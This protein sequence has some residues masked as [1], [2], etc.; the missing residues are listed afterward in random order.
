MSWTL[1]ATTTVG[2]GGV[3]NIDLQNIPGTYKSLMVLGSLRNEQ[4]FTGLSLT[5]NNNA[6]SYSTRNIDGNGSTVSS[7]SSS[8]AA[9]MAIGRIVPSSDT[10]NTFNNLKIEIPNYAG[11]TNKA[12]SIDNVTEN[13]ATGAR[14]VLVAGLWS[15]TSAITR[16]IITAEGGD[17]AEFSTLT[18]YGLA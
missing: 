7:G 9:S 1:I 15:Q 12:V 17:I 18:I 8:S 2:S 11:S 10:A 6:T 5:F 16:I 13:N 4:N 3:A 14:Q